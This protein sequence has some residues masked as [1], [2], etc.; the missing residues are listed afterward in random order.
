MMKKMVFGFVIIVFISSFAVSKSIPER[1]LNIPEDAEWDGYFWIYDDE[2]LD[3]YQIRWYANGNVFRL[4]YPVENEKYSIDKLYYENG[5]LKE[6]RCYISIKQN[7]VLEN[8]V[9]GTET[10]YDETAKQISRIEHKEKCGYECSKSLQLSLDHL[11]AVI[12]PYKQKRRYRN[13]LKLIVVGKVSSID[14]SLKKIYITYNLG[15]ELGI[16]DKV[17]LLADKDVVTFTC[18]SN[19]KGTGVFEPDNTDFPQVS[20][21]SEVRFYKKSEIKNE[22]FIKKLFSSKAGDI[23]TIGGIEFVYIPAGKNIKA[24]WMT[25]YE[26]TLGEYLKYCYETHQRLPENKQGFTLNSKYPVIIGESHYGARKY[27]SWFADKYGVETVLPQKDEWEYAARSGTTGDYYWGNDNPGDYCWYSK[28]SNAKLHPVGEKIPN[29]FGLYDMMGNVWE[30]C[31]YYY[32]RGGSYQSFEN[33]LKS[34]TVYLISYE[35]RRDK[36]TRI[37]HKN[38][39]SQGAGFR[40]IIR[41]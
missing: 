20:N 9:C 34:D 25:K 38:I 4:L 27:C 17:C 22:E 3:E 15:S 29:A 32:L 23:K 14:S 1:P 30:W 39:I 35:S 8:I 33:D 10:F 18:I 26:I 24:F 21:N 16:G 11:A 31:E 28:N 36:G 5:N 19:D 13:F 6:E 2:E 37:T 12:K 41:E 40:M 7:N